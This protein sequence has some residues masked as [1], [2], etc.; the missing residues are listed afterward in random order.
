MLEIKLANQTDVELIALLGR[1]TYSESH[2]HFIKN[3]QDLFNYNNVAFSIENVS[4]DVANT[5]NIYFVLYYNSFPAGY[6]KIVLNAKNDNVD[7]N[8]CCRLE[9]IYILNEFIP[10]KLGQTTLDFMLNKAKEL[11]F[12]TVWLTTYIKNYRA[13]KFY[14]KNEFLQVGNYSFRVGESDYDN[15]VFSKPL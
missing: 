1:I 5:N 8:N 9:R 7:S 2:G 10:L 6:A 3:Q 12:D 4:K 15:F 11:N 14:Q 13:I